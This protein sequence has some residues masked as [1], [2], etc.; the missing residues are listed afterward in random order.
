MSGGEAVAAERTQV[1]GPPVGDFRVGRRQ[2]VFVLTAV[3]AGLLVLR[4]L[5]VA[6]S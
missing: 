3:G 1:D 4:L 5:G 2:V 6:S